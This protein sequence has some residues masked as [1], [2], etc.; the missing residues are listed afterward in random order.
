MPTQD[1]LVAA[2]S[3]LV[4]KSVLRN[5]K[6]M[7]PARIDGIFQHTLDMAVWQ[8]SQI[9]PGKR[10]IARALHPG[11]IPPTGTTRRRWFETTATTSAFQT[12]T[13]GDGRQLRRL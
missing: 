9:M 3:S 8:A 12:A 13:K 11:D 2:R 10:F 5:A 7:A 4:Y 1:Q 6:Y